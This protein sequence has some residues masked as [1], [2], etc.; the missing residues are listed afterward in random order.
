MTERT[1]IPAAGHDRWLPLY[2]PLTRLLGARSALVQLVEL[3]RPRAG[4]QMLDLGCGTGTLVALVAERCPDVRITALDPDPKALER[5]RAKLERAG[6]DATFVQGFA[7]AIPA[8]DAAFDLV[9]TSFML[10]HL[11]AAGRHA[12][13]ADAH[14]VLRPGGRFL[15]LDFAPPGTRP[16]GRIARL[17]HGDDDLGHSPAQLL[18]AELTA[19]GF[20]HARTAAERDTLFGPVEVVSAQ[21]SS[22]VRTTH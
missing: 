16:R 22:D 12:A 14:R 4:E 17:L 18:A 15:A 21:R 11:E 6:H 10:H 8:P 9:V 19:V 7:D 5:A 1:F 3:A 2:D 13:L 20:E